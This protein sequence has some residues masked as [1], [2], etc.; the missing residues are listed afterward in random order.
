VLRQAGQVGGWAQ[1]PARPQ[2]QEPRRESAEEPAVPSA[3][4]QQ[5]AEPSVATAAVQEQRTEE[6][7]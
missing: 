5:S 1:P 4:W 3:A 6:V 2:A 7:R